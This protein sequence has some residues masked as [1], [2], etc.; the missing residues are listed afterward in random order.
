MPITPYGKSSG[1]KTDLSVYMTPI[2]TKKQAS[3]VTVKSNLVVM[4]DTVW[5]QGGSTEKI[6]SESL[7]FNR[8][9][10]EVPW[11]CCDNSKKISSFS[12]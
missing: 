5:Q 3:G 6:E 9:V 1:F 4:S 10:R 2:Q 11:K 8:N 12:K 7:I